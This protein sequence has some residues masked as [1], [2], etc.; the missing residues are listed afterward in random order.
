MADTQPS[1]LERIVNRFFPKSP[2]FFALLA[3]QSEHVGVSVARMVEYMETGDS[4]I[5]EMVRNDEHEADKIKIHNIH[6]LNEAFSTPIDREDIYRAIMDLDDIV[7]YCKSTVNEMETLGLKPNKYSLE[8]SLHLK[9]GVDALT[10]GFVKLKSDP[11][12]A[13]ADAAV[14]RKA[15]RVVE[16]T[17]RRAIA[18]LFQGDD[19]KE[20][21]RRR[22]IY[23]H[24]SNAA[25]R[26]AH[27]ANTLHDIIV[28]LC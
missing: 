1:L 15:E 18:E 11:A 9:E 19:Y 12:A 7:D 21:F 16:K 8:F 6:V 5:G 14:A 4:R 28:K 3:L 23:R 13:A 25:D 20:I 26:M 2:D 22:E 27:C 24:L 10:N 17:Y